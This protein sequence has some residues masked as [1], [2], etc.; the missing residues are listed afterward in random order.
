MIG[1]LTRLRQVLVNLL[2]NAIKFTERGE[3]VV[4][5]ASRALGDTRHE[6][7]FEVRDTGIGIPAEGLGRLFQPFSQVD[8]STSRKY[9]GTGLGLA[10]SNRLCELMGGT[11]QVKSTLGEGTTFAFTVVAEAAPS[12]RHVPA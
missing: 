1:D 3:V 7:Q 8:L 5:V 4:A 10:I 2:N 11:M 9:G 6:V 12:R